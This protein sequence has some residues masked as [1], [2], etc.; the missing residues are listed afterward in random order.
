[1]P[2][3]QV[4]KA[5]RSVLRDNSMARPVRGKRLHQDP[6]EELTHLVPPAL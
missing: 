4:E 6:Q 5:G 2:L 3:S 1:M